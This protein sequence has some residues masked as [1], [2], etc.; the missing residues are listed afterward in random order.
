MIISETIPT[1]RY[2]FTILN[3]SLIHRYQVEDNWHKIADLIIDGGLR[4]QKAGAEG[5]ILCANTPH[6]VFESVEEAL[7]IPIMHIA[8]TTSNGD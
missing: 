2:C 7:N 4:L 6:K 8:D 5:V 3:Q 1:L